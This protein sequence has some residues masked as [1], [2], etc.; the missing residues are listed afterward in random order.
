MCVFYV[1]FRLR[2]DRVRLR[3]QR[4]AELGAFRDGKN[5]AGGLLRRAVRLV[6]AYVHFEGSVGG[7]LAVSVFVFCPFSV[8]KSLNHF[9]TPKNSLLIVYFQV[10]RSLNGGAV[11]KVV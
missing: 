10:F 5:I 4:S 6:L 2:G 7:C 3:I 1:V 11:V 9:P 8:Y